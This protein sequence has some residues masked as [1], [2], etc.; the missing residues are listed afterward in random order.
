M[1]SSPKGCRSINYNYQR[2][3]S[4]QDL[5]HDVSMRLATAKI[6]NNLSTPEAMQIMKERNQLLKEW[7]TLSSC[8]SLMCLR[9]SLKI[10]KINITMFQN[11]K[12]QP[13]PT[14][15]AGAWTGTAVNHLSNIRIKAQNWIT[16]EHL[17]SSPFFYLEYVVLHGEGQSKWEDLRTSPMFTCGATWM[18]L[19]SSALGTETKGNQ[20]ISIAVFSIT[21]CLVL[22]KHI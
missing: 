10:P 6:R 2:Q 11:K 22:C 8:E 13:P 9:R 7:G 21:H 20:V 14:K 12:Q 4:K 3:T 19:H 15:M 17:I 1:G 18:I 5:H 16:R